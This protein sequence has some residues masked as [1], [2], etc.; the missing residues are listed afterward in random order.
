MGKSL[1]EAIIRGRSP[2]TRSW[3]R[4]F[5][6]AQMIV[7]ASCVAAGIAIFALHPGPKAGG[8]LVYLFGG[9]LLASSICSSLSLLAEPGL[10]RFHRSWLVLG[11]VCGMG[12]FVGL[13][14]VL[15]EASV[16]TT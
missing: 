13:V 10:G 5:Q 14:F 12:C 3:K 4:K 8:G 1:E 7:S 11:F 9:G 16:G 2:E 6:F 15:L